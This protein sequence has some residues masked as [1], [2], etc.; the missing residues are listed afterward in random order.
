[1]NMTSCTDDRGTGLLGY[2]EYVST[3]AVFGC[4]RVCTNDYE[5]ARN[6]RTKDHRTLKYVNVTK[7]NVVVVVVVVSFI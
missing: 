3:C 2:T 7:P 6:P 4:V 5:Y 1:M